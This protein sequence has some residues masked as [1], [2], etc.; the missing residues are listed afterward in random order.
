MTEIH[1]AIRASGGRLTKTREAIVGMLSES[2][3][4]MSKADIV[5]GLGKRKIVPDRSTVYRELV[6][7]SEN[8]IVRKS[9]LAG[10]EYYEIPDSHHHH[11]VC[12]KCHSI[13]KVEMR[14]QLAAREKSLAR[15]SGFAIISHSL[16]F[17]GYCHRCRALID[18]K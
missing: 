16:D 18:K 3:C 12:L 13:E 8:A 17:Y 11:L 4:L 6:F 10:T 7:L 1:E 15:K 9:V 2:G 5:A 14:D